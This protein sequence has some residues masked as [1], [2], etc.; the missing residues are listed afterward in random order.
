MFTSRLCTTLLGTILFA[1]PLAAQS[2]SD[3][4]ET[5]GATSFTMKAIPGG[6]FMMGCGLHEEPCAI[7]EWAD[8]ANDQRKR[9]VTVAPFYLAETET[10][11]A[12]YQQC[13]DSGVCEDNAFDG[14]DNGWG[15][16][17]RPVIEVSWDEFTSVFLPWLNAQTGAAYRLPTEAEWAYAARAGTDTRFSWGDT[18]D[19]S[20]AKFGYMAQ[21][22]GPPSTMPVKSYA[23]NAFGLYD[24][25]GNVWEF[26]SDCWTDHSS[27]DTNP[28]TCTEFVLRGGSW[29][30]APDDLRIAIRAR[31]ERTYHESGDGF[32]LAH[33]L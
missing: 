12:L 33:D 23:P 4:T 22:C 9:E 24:M 7:A 25:H 3:F 17:Q 1:W 29:L 6:T 8:K 18:I 32:R 2:H 14:G 20:N 5:V 21:M 19:C 26:V 13:I 11:W 10:T 30:N 15:K 31:H 16:G 27:T 28:A